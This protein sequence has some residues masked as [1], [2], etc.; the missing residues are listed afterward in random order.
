MSAITLTLREPLPLPVDAGALRPGVDA[1][2]LAKLPGAPE[3]LVFTSADRDVMSPV[4]VARAMRDWTPE[5]GAVPPGLVDR[6]GIDG[7]VLVFTLAVTAGSGLLFG[8]VP[9][10]R[11][12]RGGLGAE[13]KSGE[14]G[15]TAN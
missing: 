9:A 14:R 10:L 12:S 6:V 11:I 1:A 5:R 8:L 2:E 7:S 13:L 4:E 3:A 15:S